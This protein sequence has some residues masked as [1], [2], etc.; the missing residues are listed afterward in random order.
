MRKCAKILRKY[1]KIHKN[2]GSGLK[3]YENVIKS[4]LKIEK[5]Y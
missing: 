2:S 4:V 1:E 3:I 5:K